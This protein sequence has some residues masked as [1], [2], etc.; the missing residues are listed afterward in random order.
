MLENVVVRCVMKLPK[1]YVAGTLLSMCAVL[2][3]TTVLYCVGA[4]SIAF[5][6]ASK[7]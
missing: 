5:C 7:L 6:G 2:P 3:T 1:T 4:A